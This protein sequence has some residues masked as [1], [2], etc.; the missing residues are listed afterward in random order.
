MHSRPD[1][2]QSPIPDYEISHVRQKLSQWNQGAN[3]DVQTVPKTAADANM[4][5]SSSTVDEKLLII[6]A[7]ANNR[8]REQLR[9]WSRYPWMP[10]E[11]SIEETVSV[12]GTAVETLSFASPSEGPSQSTLPTIN[13]FSSA[14]KSAMYET[15]PEARPERTEYVNSEGDGYNGKTLR[16]PNVPVESKTVT[17]FECPRCRTDLQSSQMQDRNTWKSV[18]MLIDSSQRYT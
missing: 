8:R 6:L 7:A 12:I 13:T 5:E 16:V 14:P 15:S 17:E 2:E 4:P 1:E 18:H 3:Q 10:E 9:Y 11:Q